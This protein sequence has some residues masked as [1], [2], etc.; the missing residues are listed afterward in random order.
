MGPGPPRVPAD[1]LRHH[2]ETSH[3]PNNEGR[4]PIARRGTT[5]GTV[6][7]MIAEEMPGN[8]TACCGHA[9]S[10]RQVR[11]SQRLKNA[12]GSETLHK[13]HNLDLR[14]A[15]E[16]ALCTP[17]HPPYSVVHHINSSVRGGSSPLISAGTVLR[18]NRR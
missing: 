14:G 1:S 10:K 18:S 12:T 2:A 15:P 6:R 13:P 7:I 17:P 16:L 3:K 5:I 8:E 4:L 9:V 11:R